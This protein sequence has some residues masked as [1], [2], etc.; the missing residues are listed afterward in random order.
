MTTYRYWV[1][2][3]S[4]D[5]K[6]DTERAPRPIKNLLQTTKE[7][8]GKIYILSVPDAIHRHHPRNVGFRFQIRSDPIHLN[9]VSSESNDTSPLTSAPGSRSDR[10]HRDM[11]PLMTVRGPEGP[12]ILTD[13]QDLA[14]PSNVGSDTV[15]GTSLA[16]DLDRQTLTTRPNS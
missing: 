1:Q 5:K 3:N 16:I 11:P 4:F 10:I 2:Q 7:I 12:S 8:T 14:H 9:D 13:D 15:P 6:T